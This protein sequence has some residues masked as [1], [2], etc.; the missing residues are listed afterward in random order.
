[1]KFSRRH[2]PWL[3]CLVVAAAGVVPALARG[4]GTSS[5]DASIVAVDPYEFR[6]GGQPN[7]NTVEIA[8]GGT[9]SFAYPSGGSVHNV[10]FNAAQPS[11]CVQQ[12]GANVGA[13][14]PLPAFA[15]P[16][17]WSGECTFNTPGTYTFVC[18]A[19]A[20][21]TG[22]VIVGTPTATPTPTP[23]ATETPVA[24]PVATPAVTPAPTPTPW[25]SLDTPGKSVS[26]IA[27][28]MKGKLTV[29][30][31]CSTPST[32]TLTLTVSKADAKKLKLKGVELARAGAQCTGTGRVTVTVRPSATAKKALK[33]WRKALKATATLTLGSA[34][35]TRAITLSGAR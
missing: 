32:G 9:V 27:A 22:T 20:Q 19:H 28:F 13:V 12:S 30:A 17:G 5:A 35:S 15:L 18:G 10:V 29:T 7:D 21:M 25:A 26:T 31:R 2:W 23:T 1:L 16:P 11:S 8:P 34:R 14:P 33:K 4:E 24:T 3:A 6:D